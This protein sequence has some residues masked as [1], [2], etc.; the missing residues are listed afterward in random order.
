M[1]V[2]EG[3]FPLLSRLPYADIVDDEWEKKYRRKYAFFVLFH[4]RSF[5][6]IFINKFW[7]MSFIVYWRFVPSAH[8]LPLIT[9]YVFH[10]SKLTSSIDACERIFTSWAQKKKKVKIK[11]FGRKF[12]FLFLTAGKIDVISFLESSIQFT[13]FDSQWNCFFFK[14]KNRFFNFKVY[15]DDFLV[16]V[17]IKYHLIKFKCR[18]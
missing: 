16:L 14:L 13:T 15:S 9:L 12:F 4:L 11:L 2:I 18:N 5:Y 6:F 17:T 1:C 8:S 7:L 10:F 3:I